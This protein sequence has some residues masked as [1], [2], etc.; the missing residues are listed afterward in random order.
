MLIA[1]EKEP[2]FLALLFA[3]VP[4]GTGVE[5]AHSSFLFHVAHLLDNLPERSD[6]KLVYQNLGNNSLTVSMEGTI[7]VMKAFPIKKKNQVPF[8]LFHILA[9]ILLIKCTEMT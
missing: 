1:A 8:S 5:K 2:G 4:K 6:V 7:L 9:Q 3:S